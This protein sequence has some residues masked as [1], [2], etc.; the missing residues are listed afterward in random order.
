MKK[1]VILFTIFI[2]TFLPANA[3]IVKISA[4]DAVHLAL[5]NNLELQAKRKEIDI[6]KAYL[7]EQLSEEEIEKIIDQVFATV[8]PTSAK[9]MGKVMKEVTPL[10]KGKADMSH[11]SALIKERLN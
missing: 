4:D 7:P 3:D 5:E 8:A 6:L 9:D 1:I 11:V 2:I 10:V